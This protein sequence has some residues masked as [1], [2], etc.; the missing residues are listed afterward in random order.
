MAH[1]ALSEAARVELASAGVSA[2]WL[3]AWLHSAGAE[4]VEVC[5]LADRTWWEQP[6]WQICLGSEAELFRL[7]LAHG[8]RV[9]AVEGGAGLFGAE[10]LKLIN[11]DRDAW[12]YQRG[13]K[14]D[15]TV[16]LPLGDI[17]YQRL[18]WLKILNEAQPL[19]PLRVFLGTAGD[20]VL[21]PGLSGSVGSNHAGEGL[22]NDGGYLPE[23]QLLQELRRH[24]WGVRFA[25]SCTGGGL[26]ERMSR[27]PGASEVLDRSWVTYSNAAKQSLLHVP[28][29]VLEKHGAVSREVV[30]V[31]AG[32][33]RDKKNVC[34]AVSGIAGPGSDH[35]PVG[36]VWIAV[37]FPDGATQSE[38]LQLSGSR[39]LIRSQ[40]VVAAM[41]LLIEQL[42]PI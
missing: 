30:E 25:E 15:I 27:I 39:A 28:R 14:Q 5:A 20:V 18:T 4:K 9:A 41:G 26:S 12:W 37:S 22:L 42:S 21:E 2:G 35:Q 10:R 31:M 11:P 24:G 13:T 38:C 6:G 1:L 8:R 33:G 16:L 29:N 19:L 34:L 17:A 7:A 36:R 3:A 40:A 32:T 23:E